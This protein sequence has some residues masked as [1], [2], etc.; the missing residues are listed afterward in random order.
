MA[1]G[2]VGNEEPTVGPPRGEPAGSPDHRA[3]NPTSLGSVADDT[4]RA[5]GTRPDPQ[6]T[7]RPPVPPAADYCGRRAASKPA[8][9]PKRSYRVERRLRAL[10]VDCRGIT[11][12]CTDVPP[13][14]VM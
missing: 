14:R 9:V 1:F 12:E 11:S 2:N 7:D 10:T 8:E 3:R 6:R 5:G 4:G 13:R